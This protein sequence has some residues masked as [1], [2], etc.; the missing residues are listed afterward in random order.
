MR[1]SNFAPVEEVAE[2]VDVTESINGKIPDDFPVGV[3][4]RNGK[5][6]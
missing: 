6:S 3:Y 2:A 1:Q 4:I 5:F